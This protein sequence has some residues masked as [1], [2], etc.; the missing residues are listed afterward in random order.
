M[1]YLLLLFAL[2]FLKCSVDILY[3]SLFFNFFIFVL[4]IF[5]CYTH[6]H[7]CSTHSFRLSILF[8]LTIC[9]IPTILMFMMMIIIIWYQSYYSMHVMILWDLTDMWVY[10]TCVCVVYVQQKM[11]IHFST[12][13]CTCSACTFIHV[14][15]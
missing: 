4:F 8:P 11:S 5:F 3:F 14:V 2:S 9:R 15:Y 6:S 1:F 10:S 12:C 13:I 7:T